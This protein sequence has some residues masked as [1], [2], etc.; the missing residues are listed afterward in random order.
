MKEPIT[1]EI[2][3]REEVLYLK[4]IKRMI[5]PHAQEVM[6]EEDNNQENEVFVV[7]KGI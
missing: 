6:K 5:N 2:F 4:E 7:N 3:G 1:V